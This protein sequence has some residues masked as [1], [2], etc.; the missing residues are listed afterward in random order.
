MVQYPTFLGSA[1]VR[2]QILGRGLEAFLTAAA[3]QEILLRAIA[4]VSPGTALATARARDYRALTRIARQ[5]RVRLRVVR[6]SGWPFRA[7]ALRRRPGIAAGLA[8]FLLV[9]AFWSAHV[10][11]V[12]IVGN[13]RIDTAQ[14]AQIAAD[15]GVRTGMRTAAL[16]EEDARLALLRGLP[17]LAWAA[18]NRQGCRITIEVHERTAPPE[19]VPADAPCNLTA[20][21]GGVIVRTEAERGFPVV[22]AGDAVQAG[23]LLVE[24][25][26][27]DGSGGT[28][29]HHASGRV[30][31]R[32]T[33]VFTA[34][35]PLVYAVRADTGEGF[36]RRQLV[37]LGA[38]IPMSWRSPPTDGLY[39]RTFA[40]TPVMLGGLR[41]PIAVWT[42]TWMAQRDEQ[43]TCTAEEAEAMAR[44]E[45]E[46]QL[47]ETLT[48]AE[49]V[50]VTAESAVRAGVATVMLTVT[51]VE[52]IA[53]AQPIELEK[54]DM[55]EK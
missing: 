39:R 6:K 11:E 4:Q 16:D 51:C 34:S 22:Q 28:V 14:I 32:T 12:R 43:R 20:R 2:F 8:A 36:L 40:E 46:R 47:A 15:S 35:Q 42:E 30:L 7:A 26:R 9:Q 54:D 31:A 19:I 25:A 29:L 17:E 37:V 3:A 41:L 45:A 49:D 38:A 13:D 53:V 5:H 55:N 1:R 33:H 21:Q 44:T 24:G 10:W 48:A 18:V 52:D 50:V 27:T 23:D